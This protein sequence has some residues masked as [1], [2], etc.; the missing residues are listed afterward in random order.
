MAENKKFI[1]IH[2]HIIFGADDGAGSLD[3]AIELLKLDR[4]E[5]AYAVFATPHYGIV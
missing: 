2:S 4:E 3:E 5:G 1:D